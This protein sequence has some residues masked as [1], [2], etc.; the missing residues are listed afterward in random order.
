MFYNDQYNFVNIN[1]DSKF[2]KFFLTKLE[3]KVIRYHCLYGTIILQQQ[4]KVNIPD[5]YF[6]FLDTRFTIV[7]LY[8]SLLFF[9]ELISID[10]DIVFQLN[11]VPIIL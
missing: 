11:Y 5:F 1:D 10:I 2:W 4:R 9:D 8:R 3:V 7:S 6:V